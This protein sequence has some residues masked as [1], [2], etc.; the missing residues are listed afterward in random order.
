MAQPQTIRGYQYLTR[1]YEEVRPLLLRDP[2]DLLQRA[3]TS[4]SARVG[5]LATSLRVKLGSLEVSVDVRLY[6]RGIR[7]EGSLDGVARALRLELTW[8]AMQTPALFPSMLAELVVR[9]RS[10]TETQIEI[11]CSYWTPMGPIGAAI[12]ALAGHRLAEQVVYRFLIDLVE[13]LR[14]DLR[15]QDSARGCHG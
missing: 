13:Q 5:A 4:A 11:H 3:T 14:S 12:D 15:V 10:S 7:E 2:L 9:P 6:I 8:E 1:P